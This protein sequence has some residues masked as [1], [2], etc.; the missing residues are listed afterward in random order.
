MG[1][2][3]QITKEIVLKL[4]EMDKIKNDSDA[5]EAFRKIFVT[6]ANS[7]KVDFKDEKFTPNA[8]FLDI[9]R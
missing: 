9:T 3:Q 7:E 4:I 5:S 8:Y 2:A 6:V 1:E